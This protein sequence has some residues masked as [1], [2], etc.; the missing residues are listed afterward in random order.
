M[1][2][3][4]ASHTSGGNSHLVAFECAFAQFVRFWLLLLFSGEGQGFQQSTS[5]LKKLS[6]EEVLSSCI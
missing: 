4:L 3:C 5:V 6:F 2:Q 1:S